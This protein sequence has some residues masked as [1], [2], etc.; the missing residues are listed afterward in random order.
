MRAVFE[1]EPPAPFKLAMAQETNSIIG[2]YE[3]FLY[4]PPEKNHYHYVSILADNKGAFIWKTQCNQWTLTPLKDEKLTF[5]VGDKCPYFKTGYKA[6]KF[7][8]DHKGNIIGAYG[9]GNEYFTRVEQHSSIKYNLK[10]VNKPNDDE[11][12]EGMDTDGGFKE[13]NK[14]VA[15][16]LSW[17]GGK[18]GK[19][20]CIGRV[21]IDE[22][23]VKYIVYAVH[24]PMSKNHAIL[25]IYVVIS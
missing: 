19:N 15:T 3:N 12:K 1:P 22:N 25:R 8:T 10:G 14:N 24:C 13:M 7:K 9:P 21:S 20:K 5:I 6:M 16:S 23:F 17:K 11:M 2:E 4:G 18:C